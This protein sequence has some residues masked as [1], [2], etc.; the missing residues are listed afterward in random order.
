MLNPSGIGG[1]RNNFGLVILLCSYLHIAHLL[2]VWPGMK[3]TP[4][5]RSDSEQHMMPQ[6]KMNYKNVVPVRKKQLEVVKAQ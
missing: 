3:H 6:L 2:E 1:V 4:L 5:C